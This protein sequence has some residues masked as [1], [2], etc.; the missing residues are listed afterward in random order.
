[1]LFRST[2]AAVATA[3]SVEGGQLLV[4]KVKQGATVNAYGVNCGQPGMSLLSDTASL[5]RVGQAFTSRISRVP[6]TS[7]AVMSIGLSNTT[8]NGSPLP[9]SLGSYGLPGCFLYHDGAFGFAFPCASLSSNTAQ[10]T[11]N[12]PSSQVFVGMKVFLQAWAPDAS[13]NAGGLIGTNAL[14]IKIG[15]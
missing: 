1:M 11:L 13:A 3:S 7:A 5:P 6:T 4:V 2:N 12:V 14:E 10:F 8:I 15:F 9:M